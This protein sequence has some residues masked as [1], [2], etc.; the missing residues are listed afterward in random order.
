MS[1]IHF[2]IFVPNLNKKQTESLKH[3]KQN[4]HIILKK[5]DKGSAVTV[6]NTLDYIREG[7]H[8]LSNS[9][10]YIELDTDPTPTFNQ[11]VQTLIVTRQ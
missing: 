5:A 7:Y 3:L 11:L 2:V 4:P 1:N 8:Q 10:Y 6:M 9:D